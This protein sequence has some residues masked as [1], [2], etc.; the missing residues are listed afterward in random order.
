[1]ANLHGKIPTRHP[2]LLLQQHI[3]NIWLFFTPM[4]K[5]NVQT[6]DLKLFSPV[7]TAFVHFLPSLLNQFVKRF[8]RVTQSTK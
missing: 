4:P 7:K 3:M 8:F 6:D 1:M 5:T 2:E